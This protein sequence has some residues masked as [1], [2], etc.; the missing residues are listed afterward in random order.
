MNSKLL[1]LAALGIAGTLVLSWCC[2]D[3]HKAAKDFCLSNSWTYNLV[4]SVDEEYG[5]CFF[6]SGVGCRD[7]IVL[8]DECSFIP[9]TSSI[10]TEE[11]RL[12]GCEESAKSWIEDFEEWED[13]LISWKDESEAGASFVRNWVA[14]YTKESAKWSADVECVADFVD[15]SLSTSFGD[16]V[17]IEE[18]TGSVEKVDF[19]KGSSDIYSQD[20]LQAAV[21]AIMNTVWNEWTV[22][23]KMQDISY[24]WDEES[25]SQLDYCKELSG[26]VE[27]CVFFKTNF[28]I[29]EQDV[30]MAW[31]FEPNKTMKDYGWF[32]WRIG[33]GEWKVLTSGY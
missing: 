23:V 30:E 19:W 25:S 10:D 7:D 26:D 3:T 20:E 27:Q 28:F 6:P 4:T 12:S 31:A 1:S 2:N 14:T 15:G 17:L 29:P 32:L 5:E 18:L 13:I 33:S 24:Q 9:D 8:T 11:E 16:P 21:D 22:K